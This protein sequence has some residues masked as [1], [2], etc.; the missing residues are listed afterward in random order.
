MD[1]NELVRG[2]LVLG[3]RLGRLVSGFVDSFT[4]DPALSRAVDN[5]PRLHPRALGDHARSLRR[6]IPGSDLTEQRKQFLDAHLRAL[7][8]TA[9]RLDGERIS[10]V[11]EVERY[12]QVRIRPGDEDAYA[13]AHR[14][15]DVALAGPGSLA[16]R[17]TAFR[18]ADEV[19][20]RRLQGA[21]QALSSALRDRV[22]QKYALPEQEIVEYRVVTNKPWSGFNY[23]LGGYRSRVAINADMGHRMANLPHLVAHESYPGHHTEHCR[24]ES[25]LVAKR[26]HAE[27]SI[28]LINTPQCLMAEGMADLGLHAAVG[29]GWGLWT[30]QIFRD[31]GL[32]MDGELSEKVEAA[33]SGLLTVRQDAALLLHDRGADQDDVVA[34][35]RRWLLVPERRARQMVRFLADPLWR[36]YTTTYV[37]GVRLVRAWLDVRAPGESLDSRYL[38]LLDEPLVPN[39]LESQVRDGLSWLARNT[40]ENSM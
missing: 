31:L 33:A 32:R 11:D 28:F 14:N 20:A 18:A 15:L 29:P 26:G 7:E 36:A 34:H 27:Q 9:R 8:C 6:E 40:H 12:F 1:A 17:L 30:E 5:E 38:R 2:Y 4:G 35:L 3:L 10:F 23:Y 16:D 19:P 21:V 13:Q 25:G 39:S 37:E 22:R 24:K